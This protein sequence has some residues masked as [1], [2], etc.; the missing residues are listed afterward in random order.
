LKNYENEGEMIMFHY[1]EHFARELQKMKETEIA[2]SVLYREAIR[3]TKALGQTKFY[4]RFLL[5]TSTW[6]ISAGT[7]LKNR[8][9]RV[10][11]QKH[12]PMVSFSKGNF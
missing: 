9:E 10:S 3:Q 4:V 6:M 2:K 8:A 5:V 7:Y 12:Q 1:T 11:I